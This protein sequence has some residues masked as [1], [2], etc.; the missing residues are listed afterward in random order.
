MPLIGVVVEPE[1]VTTNKGIAWLHQLAGQ[2]GMGQFVPMLVMGALVLLV[3]GKMGQFIMQ[4]YVRRF[5]LSVRIGC[6]VN[7]WLGQ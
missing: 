1:M 6:P 7:L 2:P 4:E 5:V 3:G